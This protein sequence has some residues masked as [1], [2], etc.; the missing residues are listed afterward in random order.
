MLAFS[1]HRQWRSTI[2]VPDVRGLDEVYAAYF[3]RL[4]GV[5][6]FAGVADRDAAGMAGRRPDED[7]SGGDN[8]WSN[9]GSSFDLVAPAEEHIPVA[10]H[11]AHARYAVRNEKPKPWLPEL[12]GGRPG[13]SQMHVHIP[14]TG[15][16]ELA[17]RIDG[18][19]RPSAPEP[20]GQS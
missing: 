20:W 9:R 4:H 11:I 17:T 2:R 14:Q 5:T 6:R 7:W 15:D 19:A 13:K 12:H 18:A 1:P 8:T 16:E 3:E 10:T